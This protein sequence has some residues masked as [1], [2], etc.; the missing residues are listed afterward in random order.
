MLDQN[1]KKWVLETIDA[2]IA[3]QDARFDEKL[4]AM[5]ARFDEKLE[6]MEARFDK[7]LEDLEARF[8]KKLEDLEARFDEKLE[9]GLERIQM[10]FDAIVENRIMPM[11]QLH[12]EV[13]PGAYKSYDNLENRVQRLEENYEIMND[14]LN[15]SKVG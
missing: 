2:K 11:L 8:D 3:E 4:E 7:K 15:A 5:E 6:D 10:H 1:D 12:L 13:L 9:A 14:K